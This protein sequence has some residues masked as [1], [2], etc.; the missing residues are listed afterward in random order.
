MSFID[1]RCPQTFT[2]K[3]SRNWDEFNGIKILVNS[4]PNDKSTAQA[5]AQPKHWT[6][7][8]LDMNMCFACQ[9]LHQMSVFSRDRE[10]GQALHS[11]QGC[12]VSLPTGGPCCFESGHRAINLSRCLIRNTAAFPPF[13]N[14]YIERFYSVVMINFKISSSFSW[15]QLNHSRKFGQAGEF[16]HS[17]NEIQQIFRQGVFCWK[18][19]FQRALFGEV[20]IWWTS[21]LARIFSWIVTAKFQK[22]FEVQIFD[23]QGMWKISKNNSIWIQVWM[24][25][26]EIAPMKL[27]STLQWN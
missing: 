25:F 12:R 1:L 2:P 17:F 21:S 16:I 3:K 22:L 20:L 24:F 7:W 23:G 5:R 26:F 13:I 6:E 10:L 18:S 11:W 9:Q 27:F 15:S 8:P 14:E 4:K 19:K